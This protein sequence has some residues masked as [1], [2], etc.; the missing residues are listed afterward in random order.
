MPRHHALRLPE[1]QYLGELYDI[2][3]DRPETHAIQKA[4]RLYYA[5]YAP[6]YQ[7]IVELRGLGPG[8]YRVR[9]YENERDLG[10]V[11]GPTARLAVSFKRHL[12]LEASPD[13]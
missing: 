6:D 7:G 3:F 10:V 5:M 4:G 9:D 13:R 11:S 1:G 12:L 2:G 8:A